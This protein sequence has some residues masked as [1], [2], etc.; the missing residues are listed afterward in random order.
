M[1]LLLLLSRGETGCNHIWHH[2]KRQSV[3]TC[4]LYGRFYNGILLPSLTPTY[5]S[6][7]SGWTSSVSSSVFFIL[8]ISRS[9]NSILFAS[10]SISPLQDL[11]LPL[12]LLHSTLVLV[13]LHRRDP[14]YVC[15]LS[16]S[17]SSS[18]FSHPFARVFSSLLPL[19]TLSLQRK[20]HLVQIKRRRQRLCAHFDRKSKIRHFPRK[21]FFS[22]FI[23]SNHTKIFFFL[24][25]ISA[26]FL[27]HL[28]QINAI[29]IS[30]GR[31]ADTGNQAIVLFPDS[32]TS[33]VPRHS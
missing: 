16:S 1:L 26:H 18:D 17:S 31:C 10:F 19:V 20:S 12:R 33:L 2:N 8:L 27:L 28:D 6:A 3:A 21:S 7:F 11:P 32:S 4:Y 15:V 24:N 25:L 23:L 14:Y 9:F 30:F 29:V 5:P 22:F 13:L